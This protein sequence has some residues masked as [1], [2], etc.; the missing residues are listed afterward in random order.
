MNLLLFQI[1][2]LSSYMFLH[3]GPYKRCLFTVCSG[4]TSC[5]AG[6]PEQSWNCQGF[7]GLSPTG[8]SHAENVCTHDVIM[9]FCGLIA[10]D[11][12]LGVGEPPG[13]R[14]MC[15]RRVVEIRQ[16]PRHSPSVSGKFHLRCSGQ[17]NRWETWHDH[18]GSHKGAEMRAGQ[19]QT[20]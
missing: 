3:M 4:Q 18:G 10:C 9:C 16:G 19:V 20:M 12:W 8:P 15:E 14:D 11:I 2:M 17:G 5:P 7:C 13:E 1:H 6:C